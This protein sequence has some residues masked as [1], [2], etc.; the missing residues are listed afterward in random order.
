MHVGAVGEVP[1]LVVLAD[2]ERPSHRAADNSSVRGARI[3][4]MRPAQLETI[5]LIASSLPFVIF[6][7][8]PVVPI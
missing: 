6:F 8:L 4:A 1:D 7:A 2:R 5:N 3:F